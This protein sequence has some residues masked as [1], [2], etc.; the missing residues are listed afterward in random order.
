MLDCIIHIKGNGQTGSRGNTHLPR[1]DRSV[2]VRDLI[3]SYTGFTTPIINHM[4][5]CGTCSPNDLARALRGAPEGINAPRIFGY[6]VSHP[7]MDQ[8]LWLEEVITHFGRP[9]TEV[10]FKKASRDQILQYINAT[11]D[12]GKLEVL[13]HKENHFYRQHVLLCEAILQCDWAPRM[14]DRPWVVGLA[15]AL[16]MGIMPSSQEE[17][18]SL[19]P[20]IEVH[21]A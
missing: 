5:T 1:R 4:K 12:N 2:P 9:M 3:K 16:A 7:G 19:Q 20:F 17:L 21:Q 13:C 14:K 6:L 8:G 11:R 10:V 18:A 15:K